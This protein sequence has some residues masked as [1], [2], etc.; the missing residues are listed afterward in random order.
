MGKRREVHG[1]VG[2][3]IERGEG[4]RVGRRQRSL[5]IPLDLGGVGSTDGTGTVRLKPLVDALGVELMI[6]G[7][8]PQELP[9]LKVAHADHTHR[10]LRLMV[11]G[12][13]PV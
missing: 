8:D 4:S 6:A 7:Q 2:A 10:L 5:G 13:E 1:L 12:V 3:S 11:V 9:I